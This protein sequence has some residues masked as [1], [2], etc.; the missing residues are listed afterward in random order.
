[1]FLAM[2]S[3]VPLHTAERIE[4]YEIVS[5]K[6]N[7]RKLDKFH[8][9]VK[10]SIEHL[11]YKINEFFRLNNDPSTR[12]FKTSLFGAQDFKVYISSSYDKDSNLW[13]IDLFLPNDENTADAIKK[14]QEKRIYYLDV[15]VMDSEGN[16]ALTKNSLYRQSII[17]KLR[18]FR[19]VF[20]PGK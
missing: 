17:N 4:G 10:T 7:F 3:C 18:E 5:G 6:N 13:F 1:V 16:D 20:H 8:F 12:A 19:N 2:Q 15:Q 11:N 14:T 9:Q